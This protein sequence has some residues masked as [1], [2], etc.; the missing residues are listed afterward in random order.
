MN[1]GGSFRKR[2]WRTIE[3]PGVQRDGGEGGRGMSNDFHERFNISADLGAERKRFVVAITNL[4]LANK[5]SS[6]EGGRHT[7]F[8]IPVAIAAAHWA[9]AR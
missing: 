9:M 4:F 5:L 7:A 1:A 8:P 3:R 6:H 2:I